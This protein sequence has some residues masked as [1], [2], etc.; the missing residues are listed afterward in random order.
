MIRDGVA[1]VRFLHWLEGA[2]G[3]E[4]VTEV[5]AAAKLREFRAAGENFVGEAFSTISAYR[6]H[7]ALPHYFPS[8]ASDVAL[9]PAGIYLVDSGA[10][11]LDGTT[12]ITRTVSFDE[13]ADQARRDYTLV[14]KG[15]I[16]LS[17][18]RFPQGT[19]GS[20]IDVIARE[21]LWRSRMNFGH[22]TG[23]G[24]GFYLN[25]HEGPQRI[26][27]QHN[28]TPLRPGMIISNEPGL[29]RP[30]QYGIRIENLIVVEEDRTTEFGTFLAFETVTL[31]PY[32]R[33]LIDV[34]LLTAA[35]RAWVDD[36]HRLVRDR[37]LGH[38]DGA[39]ADWLDAACEPL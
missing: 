30:E 1:M 28:E 21:H 32:D 6:G 20:M 24:V 14:L 8:K 26:S 13:P 10:Q 15:H 9:Q 33:K 38:L 18:L 22:G 12:D 19:T 31:C 25:V 23:H 11:Y 29:Y 34:E 39:T 16:G 35:E 4:D 36:Y 5:S 17:T 37:L 7:A 2:V 27:T 3:S